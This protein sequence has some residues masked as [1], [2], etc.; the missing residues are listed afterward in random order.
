MAHFGGDEGASGGLS[1]VGSG[2]RGLR[3]PYGF[4]RGGVC[5]LSRFSL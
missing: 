4:T 1:R 3:S 5:Y 2:L